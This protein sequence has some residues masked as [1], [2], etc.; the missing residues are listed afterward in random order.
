ME[1]TKLNNKD[2]IKIVINEFDELIEDK[3][4]L[5]NNSRKCRYVTNNRSNNVFIKSDKN[6]VSFKKIDGN[7]KNNRYR[8]NRADINTLESLNLPEE[9]IPVNPIIINND[10]D[11]NILNNSS[12]TLTSSIRQRNYVIFRFK[13]I[14]SPFM[15]YSVYAYLEN[16]VTN[17]LTILKLRNASKYIIEYTKSFNNPL[18]IIQQ[19]LKFTENEKELITIKGVQKKTTE[20]IDLSNI[21]LDPNQFTSAI[22][23]DINS[24]LLNGPD[25]NILNIIN[26]IRNNEF[27]SLTSKEELLQLAFRMLEF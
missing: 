11:L 9:I 6:K 17:V 21:V 27:I 4:L 15:S 23:T 7:L 2:Y 3:T 1:K 14:N 19:I 12:E 16:K 10:V 25:D 18:R 20:V 26:I 8:K 22:K 5:N 13:N 24:L